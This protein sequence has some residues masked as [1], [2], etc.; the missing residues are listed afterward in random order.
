V[1]MSTSETS[2]CFILYQRHAHVI[3][4]NLHHIDAHAYS[5]KKSMSIRWWFNEQL[6][7]LLVI[8]TNALPWSMNRP[9]I[10]F[11][12]IS[13]ALHKCIIVQQHSFSIIRT[14]VES[15]HSLEQSE[16]HCFLSNYIWNE[17]EWSY[18]WGDNSVQQSHRQSKHSPYSY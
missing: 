14:R 16:R 6:N 11:N 12:L 17:T 9:V 2:L 10:Y 3:I 1:P 8:S 13:L 15:T 4:S 18:V 7:I 5:R